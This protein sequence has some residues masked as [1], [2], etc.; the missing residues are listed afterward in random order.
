MSSTQMF[1]S[2]QEN[3]SWRAWLE[4][5]Q[6]LHVFIRKVNHIPRTV[7]G[8]GV[9]LGLSLAGSYLGTYG[10]V[11]SFNWRPAITFMDTTA[12]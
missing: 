2:L 5:G 12:G 3:E 8:E 9:H 10:W 4:I 1:P 7:V 6:K 11:K